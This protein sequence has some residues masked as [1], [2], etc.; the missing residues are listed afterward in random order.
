L[1]KNG[2]PAAV[3]RAPA[4]GSSGI[5]VR[6]L[7]NRT[8][9][10]L[11]RGSWQSAFG[12]RASPTRR[13]PQRIPGSLPALSFISS[14]LIVSCAVER[15]MM[16][17]DGRLGG[18]TAITKMAK[19]CRPAVVGMAAEG[20]QIDVTRVSIS[21]SEHEPQAGCAARARR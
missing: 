16:P 17:A 6:Y 15:E 12:N 7:I 13:A 9:T 3:D 1:P 4:A 20:D 18:G 19:T 2:C 14:T 11:T 10:R 8:E 21:S 5:S